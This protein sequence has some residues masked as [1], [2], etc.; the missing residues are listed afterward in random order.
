MSLEDYERLL[1][2]QNYKCLICDK[3][4][5]LYVDHCHKTGKVRGLLC[6]LC[7]RGIGL[8]KE[9]VNSLSRAINFLNENN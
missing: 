9:D 2:E 4:K 8:F 5:K 1:K 6:D 7:N 3:K